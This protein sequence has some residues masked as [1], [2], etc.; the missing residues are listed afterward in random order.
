MS[1]VQ[2]NIDFG[3]I[4]EVALKGV[5]RATVFLGFGVNAALDP[6]FNKYQLTKIAK[7][8]LLPPDVDAQTVARFK[9]EFKTWIVGNGL[10]ELIETFSVFLERLHE[11]CLV[12]QNHL[13]RVSPKDL[14]EQ[15]AN[16][17]R[18]GLPKK[19]TE[20][21]WFFIR[22]AQV[23]CGTAAEF[24]KSRNIPMSETSQDPKSNPP[25]TADPRD[26]G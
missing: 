2:Y 13:E 7:I 21:C 11:A 5:R 23:T 26:S 15:Q 10:R 9:E 3:K 4:L 1:Q 6:E 22:E 12:I 16:F 24:A 20:I 18:Q 25:N 14:A 8:Q 17:V 19:L